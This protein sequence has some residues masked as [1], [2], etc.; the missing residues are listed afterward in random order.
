VALWPLFCDDREASAS[1]LCLL[2]WTAIFDA[3]SDNMHAGPPSQFTCFTGT[4][5]QTL[6]SVVMYQLDS[7]LPDKYVYVCARKIRVCDASYKI[8]NTDIHKYVSVLSVSLCFSH[9]RYFS[10]TLSLCTRQRPT[11]LERQ[12]V[13]VEYG[14]SSCCILQK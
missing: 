13:S 5:G 2:I 7:D 10:L 1:D 14:T 12:S 6:T 11:K 9:S 4:K 8:T 3:G